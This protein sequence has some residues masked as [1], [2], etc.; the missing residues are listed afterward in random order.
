MIQNRHN[1]VFSKDKRNVV[2]LHLYL[3]YKGAFSL[4]LTL[5]RWSVFG[6]FLFQVVMQ[7]VLDEL[8]C[9]YRV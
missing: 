1:V 9:Y 6:V 4:D 3:I 8:V 7:F 5:I 2:R